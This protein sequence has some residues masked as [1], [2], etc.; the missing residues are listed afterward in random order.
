MSGVL[1]SFLQRAKPRR[2][3]S[4]HSMRFHS[5]EHAG[6]EQ[7]EPRLLLVIDNLA[8]IGG[9]VYEDLTGDGLTGDDARRSNVQVE[10]FR[11]GG[12]NVFGNGGGDDVSLGTMTT[13]GT[14]TFLFE[15][16]T[17]GR[18]FLQQ[19]SIAGLIQRPGEDVVTVDISL[20]DAQGL[21]GTLIDQFDDP[22]PPPDPP[23]GAS[24]LSTGSLIGSSSVVATG[25]IGMERDLVVELTSATGG[26]SLNANA[27]NLELLEFNSS[28]TAA[29]RGAV[30]WDGTDG[31][32]LT[33]DPT[34]LGGIDLTDSGVSNGFRA[35]AGADQNGVTLTVRVHTDATSSSE[36]TIAVANTGG[37]A[38]D[39]LYIPFSDFTQ[40]G[41]AA[42]PAD[43]AN[44]GAVEFVIN[45]VT[46]A[47]GQFGL[48]SSQGPSVTSTSFANFQPLSLGDLVWNDVN[49][50]GIFD[51]GSESGIPDVTVQLYADTDGN[52]IF[53]SGTDTFVSAVDTGAGGDY[54]FQ[55]LIPGDYVVRIP[56][57]EFDPG[58]DLEQLSASSTGNDP[59][60]DPDDD[61]NSDDNGTLLT[62]EGAVA[63]A[64]TLTA[65][66][67]PDTDG[68]TDSDTNLTVDFGFF[69]PVDVQITKVDT[70]D[71]VN[72]GGSF[73]YTLTVTNNGPETATGVVATDVL[74]GGVS[75]VSSSASQGSISESNGTVTASLGTLASGSTATVTINVTADDDTV[76]T[77]T[78]NASVTTDQFDIVSS[79]NST[80]EETTVLPVIDLA[81]T[82]TDS[83][84]PVNA[85]GTL[86][87]TVLVTNSGP[88]MATGVILTDT[89]PAG[90]SFSTAST[91]T[92]TVGASNGVVT[93]NIGT[94][95]SGASATVTINVD[96]DDSTVGSVTNN[97][98]V[99]ANE[100]DLN[101]TNNSTSEPTIV[102]PLVDVSVVKSD[103]VDPVN[104]G[105]QLTY[106]L[107]VAN[108]GPSTA[109]GVTLTDTLPAG[110]SFSSGSST[111]GTV[112]EAGGTVTANVGTLAAGASETVTLIVDVAGTTSGTITNAAT[113]VSNEDDSDNAN[114]ATSEPTTVTPVID[115]AVSKSDSPDAVNAGGVLTYT[116]LVTNN[117][118][119]PATNVVLT[120][121]LPT[122][123][124]FDSA[125]TS[126]GAVSETGGTVTAT[127]GTLASGASATL[128]IV[129][130][131]SGSALGTITNSVSATAAETETDNA[132]NSDSEQTTVTPIIDLSLSKTDDVDPVDAGGSLVYTL[133]VSNAGPSTATSVNVTDVLPTDV[134][135]T[136][137]ASSQ[138]AVSESNGTVTANVGTL[139][140]GASATVTITVAASGS[141][142][143]TFTNNASVAGNEAEVTTA[144]N[145]V[146]EETVVRPVVDVRISKSDSAD[147]VM[148]GSSFA[149]T[150]TVTNDGPSTATNVMVTDI[151]PAGVSL[152]SSSASQGSVSESGGTVTASLGTLNSGASATI[153]LNVDV[154]DSATGTLTNSV[155]LTSTETDTNLVNNSD[156]ELTAVT[157]VVDLVLS[158]S[159]SIDPVN[160]GGAIAY[161]LNVTNN[162]PSM[163]TGVVITDLLPPEV[164]FSSA[165]ASQ[166]SVSESGGTVTANIG[167]LASGASATIT[168]NV[169]VDD[170]ARGGISNSAAVVSNE[171]DANPANNSAI[172]PTTVTPVVDVLVTKIDSADPVNAGGTIIYSLFVSNSGPSTANNVV[173]TDILPTGVSF[174]SG[175]VSQGSVSESGGV[176]T[177][178]LG[179]LASGGSATVTLNVN[180]DDSTQGTISNTVSVVSDETDTN[181]VNNSD[182]ELTSVTPVVDLALTKSD[183]VDPVNAGG[184]F[185]YTLTLTNN[186]PSTATGV[187]I[188]DLL[189]PEVTFDSGSSSQGAVSESSGT[190]TA[191]I[192][193]LASGASA[194]VTLNVTATDSARG[195]ITNSASVTAT[196][197]ETDAA[198]NATTEPTTIVPVVDVRISKSD[199][200]DP[201]NS[202]GSFAYTLT[203]TNEGPSLASDVIVTDILPAGV[204]FATG[205]ASQGTVSESSGTVTAN[206]GSLD[207]GDSAII[208][209]NVN[210]A[211]SV[212]GTVTNTVSVVSTETDSNPV[213]NSDAE[214]TT[215]TPVVD[216]AVTKSDSIDPVNAGDSFVYTLT[217]TNN[218]PSTANGVVVT[219]LLPPE[220][221]F[222]SGSASQGIV[223]ES[224]GTVTAAI[225][226]LASGAS[227]TV[228]L[229]IAVNDSARGTITN[230]ASVTSDETETNGADNSAVETTDVTPVV[231][232]LVTKIDSADPVNAG[233]TLVYSMFVRNDGP[234][235]ATGVTLTDSLP[236]GVTVRS[237][238]SSQGTVASTNGVVTATL[239]S[240]A[241]GAQARVSVTVDIDNSTTGTLTNTA[242]VTAN[243]MDSNASNNSDTEST[244]VIPIADLAIT[245][246]DNLDSVLQ[247]GTVVYTLS[248]SNNGPSTATGVVVTDVLPTGF[249]FSSGTA[250]QGSVS[251]SSGTVTAVLGNLPSGS[252][253]TITLNVVAADD[254]QGLLTNTASVTGT[255][256]DP[257][258]AN[259][260]ATETTTV[261]ELPRSTL[262]GLVYVDVN[263][264][265][266]FD[267]GEPGISG[268]AVSLVPIDAMGGV[269]GATISEVTDSSG[270]YRF[271][272][273]AAGCYR[274][275][276]TQPVGFHQGAESVGTSGGTNPE[277]NVVDAVELRSGVDATAYNFGEVMPSKRRFLA[278]SG[279]TPA[280]GGISSQSSLSGRVYSDA[281]G[282]GQFDSGD[283]PIAD[284]I[285][286]LIPIDSSG[287]VTGSAL[288]AMSG[289]NGVY[290]FS[291]VLSGRYR[292]I[293]TQPSTHAQG[294]ERVGSA[295]GANTNRSDDTI[296]DISLSPS[297]NAIGY[298][299]AD[300]LIL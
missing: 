250:S 102:E 163:A 5:C 199:S 292:L 41:G 288:T 47:D 272:N 242:T 197:T 236:N 34:G 283:S 59:A 279:S 105:S 46:A 170:S 165:S 296:D 225:G 42:N 275:V 247:G 56:Q 152:S 7:L 287:Q 187:V 8:S 55:N 2:K 39:A 124:S 68:D 128:S 249:S 274:V 278:S 200:A 129:T 74:P 282:N 184:S 146:S 15:R 215:I 139:A 123:V 111:Q 4:R 285:L 238:S 198:N 176:V 194:T 153:T 30:V 294:V 94:L 113:V 93:A 86:V 151:L 84:D 11:D 16:L 256:T 159:D 290:R 103:S 37:A 235:T 297:L 71:P 268:V 193:T 1:K 223:T 217:V 12:D 82:K 295:G 190:V 57:S 237:T 14:G 233:G 213:N 261:V 85:G 280:N 300:G 254:A 36:G 141:A 265:G 32:P 231:D 92:G 162:G 89:L 245:K 206:L 177:A 286:S 133:T 241:S 164:S 201:V 98:S 259:N 104:A 171:T 298:D 118:P 178:S 107:I 52:G 147:P 251:E 131:V 289:A 269:R 246:S 78:N 243:E 108:A 119:S 23:Q 72:A 155:S 210:V 266:R 205:S 220:V 264:N 180:V 239:G 48:V 73:A 97:A 50:N 26:V 182:T 51:S 258:T 138:G 186:G 127:V 188:T 99:T 209:L 221:A 106:T 160:A 43:F 29:G 174:A 117:G 45:G 211:D 255:E 191:N 54:L 9:V 169:D 189:P 101:N 24:A 83:P 218:G 166:G 284:V 185:A 216:L 49:N 27:F 100:T 58:G 18:Y 179:T 134:S 207:S 271:T 204:N 136:T 281:N 257:E 168:L 140:S 135:F 293:E 87:Y 60:P 291:G 195:T 230:S 229:N 144:N 21:P 22:D 183:S 6:L 267:T 154:A 214:L 149:Y 79:N 70:V 116:V 173:V 137:A 114:N 115:L 132:N 62:G 122:E 61:V 263:R 38:T 77:V 167:T 20:A 80:N 240:L 95:A 262:A 277:D 25:V 234:S 75:H 219:D 76:G 222:D 13:D 273:L 148:A 270:A 35:I 244:T 120:D 252:T 158:K 161:T 226:T 121:V 248:V 109:T 10:L 232:V 3:S 110:V 130:T 64:V 19:D 150:L 202:G 181:G 69:Q 63:Q 67:E 143:G 212:R 203:V 112:S 172:E 142:T 125:S 227:A 208:T 40:S 299:F 65:D 88:S 224:G 156:T 175:T 91:T 96:V 260:T 145:S 196:E 17:A 31:D 228:T 253:A 157:P 33:V 44:V 90:V 66:S 192:G 81:V 276:E 53:T 28:T 126:Q